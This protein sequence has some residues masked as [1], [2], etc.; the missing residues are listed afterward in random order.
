M[1]LTKLSFMV[2][3]TLPLLITNPSQAKSLPMTELVNIDAPQHMVEQKTIHFS[4]AIQAN[5]KFLTAKQGYESSSDEYWF[6]V[7]GAQLN[8]GVNLDISQ[9]EALI[10]LSGK[11]S[12]DNREFD[13]NTIDP[14]NI[15][16]FKS[17]HKLTTPFQQTVSQ[18][19]LA[20]A[21][22]FPNSSA[23]KLD[24]A[25]GNGQFK[26]LVNE[27]LM[28]GQRFV[29]NVKEKNSPHKLHLSTPSMNY[30]SGQQVDIK[31]E[32]KHNDAVLAFAKHQGFIKTP[33]GVKHP[34]KLI[35]SPSGFRVEIPG[36]IANEKRGQLYEL[37]VESQAV[38]KALNIRRNGK[39]AFAV[40]KPTAAMEDNVAVE[41]T[42]ANINLTVAS[43]GRY[44]ISGIVYG[45]NKQG[46]FVPFMLSRSAYYLPAGEHQL[47]L[48]FDQ[49]IITSSG[50]TAP[51]NVKNLR[52]MD[53]SR[54]ALL[55]Q[56]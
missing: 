4:Q 36:D 54:M 2:L 29:I 21:N 27:K 12:A 40:A 30:L 52:L 28:P 46:R 3:S 49:S 41:S 15:E 39:I 43:E 42:G 18:Q 6:E 37:H 35:T 33:S 5:G 32:F 1:K 25:V 38:D 9:A 55:Q 7:T 16:L 51:F 22:I 11:T 23:V 53:Q 31:A 17:N 50:L 10:R 8:K 48:V 26:L 56:M 45:T 24:K 19:Q 13:N 20:T 44:E 34:V 14:S 47:P